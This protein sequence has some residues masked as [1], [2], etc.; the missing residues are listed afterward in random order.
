MKAILIFT[1]C[2]FSYFNNT[3]SAQIIYTDIPDTILVFP[4]ELGNF[5]SLSYF[6]DIDINYDSTND[7]Q[8]KLSH[9]E[10]LLED[11]IWVIYTVII[12]SNNAVATLEN[13]CVQIF[14]ENDTINDSQYWPNLISDPLLFLREYYEDWKLDD[15]MCNEPN[16]NKYF[17]LKLM[18]DGNIF[19]GWHSD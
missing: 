1:L 5:N 17:G 9:H 15:W 3:A 13:G 14:E 8:F 19:Y 10:Y 7:V 16:S 12:V 6:Y 11:L 18:I 4:E 2:C